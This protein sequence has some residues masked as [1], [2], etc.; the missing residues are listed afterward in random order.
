[1]EEKNRAFAAM[2]EAAKARLVP[3]TAEDIAA[4]TDIFFDPEQS[5]FRLTTLGQP[6]QISYPSYDI[7]P[8]LNTW[9][10]LIVLHYLDV[11]DGTRPT[12]RIMS[13]ASLPDGLARGGG[14]DRQCELTIAQRI[15]NADPDSLR[16]AC[17][18]LGAE[19][20]P[21]NADLCAVFPFLPLYPVTL[22][23]WFA[24]EELPGAGRMFLDESASHFMSVEDAITVG[25][26]I[27]DGILAHLQ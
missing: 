27:L 12:S 19:I 6:L 21:S 17:E 5:V 14:F 7:T 20:V 15:A 4:K 3:R 11:A 1:M 2:R 8:E 9:H 13:F 16:R 18:A 24:D 25:G 26:L 22:K 23:I 10:H